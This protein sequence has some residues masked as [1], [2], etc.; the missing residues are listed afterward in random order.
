MRLSG[1]RSRAIAESICGGALSPRR[2]HHRAFRDGVGSDIDDGVVLWFPAPASYTGED[3]VEMQGHGNPVLLDLLVQRCC[4]LGARPARPGE[5]TERAFLNDRLDLAQAEAVAD[6]INAST[7]AAAR[8]AVRSLQGEFSSAVGALGTALTTLRVHVESALDF[9]DEDIDFL[10]ESPVREHMQAVLDQA[11]NLLRT[12]TAGV[13]LQEGAVVVIAGQPNV[14]KSSL[15]NA[16]AAQDIAIVTDVPGTTRDV[17]RVALDL[18]GI[19]TEV[20][21]TAGVRDAEDAV[22]REGVRRARE[23]LAQADLV[24]LVFDSA[25]GITADDLALAATCVTSQVIWVAN[26]AD[27]APRLA[28]QWPENSVQ[29]SART[30]DGLDALRASI[31]AALA[32]DTDVAD[33]L[34][35][36][37]ARRRHVAALERAC[38]GL[39]CAQRNL[40]ASSGG[41]LVAEDLRGAHAALESIT[42][43]YTADDLLGEIFSAFCIGK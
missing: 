6:V 23:Q 2:V 42:G 30:G 22:E 3:V 1:A 39:Q 5:F 20:I 26:K 34:G 36:L 14:G 35:T 8:A 11:E 16:L 17:I 28:A 43:R 29:V 41:E 7:A 21:D 38:D 32:N 4:A 40:L 33:G 15:L 25:V 37:S 27:L 19:A 13:R 31:S 10:S 12:A 24:L 18:D 9:P